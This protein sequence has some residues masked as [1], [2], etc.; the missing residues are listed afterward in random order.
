MIDELVL[1]ELLAFPFEKVKLPKTS[2]PYLVTSARMGCNIC[3]SGFNIK[4]TKDYPYFTLHIVFE[5]CSFFHI[6]NRDYLLKKGDAFLITVNEDHSYHNTQ[7][8]DLGLMWIELSGNSSRELL[9]YFALNDIRTI[10]ALYTDKITNQLA[11]ILLYVK[12]TENLNPYKLSAMQYTLIM[13]LM[14]TVSSF[15]KKNPPWVISDALQYINENFTKNIKVHDLTDTLK[16]SNTYLNTEF[17]KYVGTSPYQY[18][19]LKRLE[20][21]CYLLDNTDLS[22]QEIAE[23]SGFYDSAHFNRIFIQN[24]HI[25]PTKYHKRDK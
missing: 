10:D 7:N 23:R 2:N 9:D 18:I 5:G 6:A 16:I 25:Q 22:C 20:Y 4:R 17:H 21:A 12:S 19:K 15:P 8:S 14:E 1:K 3:H 24:L 11:E 13:D